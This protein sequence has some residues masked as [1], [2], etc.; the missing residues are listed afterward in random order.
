MRVLQ[1]VGAPGPTVKFIDQVTRDTPDD[2][3]FVYFSWRAALAARYDVVHI[4]WPEFFVRSRWPAVGAVKRAVTLIL[5]RRWRARGVPI[6]HT[7][8]NLAPHSELSPRQA[9]VVERI[10]GGAAVRVALNAGTPPRPGI[11]QVVIPHGDYRERFGQLPPAHRVPGRLLAI[12]RIEPYKNVPRLIRLA[13]QE[14]WELRVVGEPGPGMR[15]P[16]QEQLDALDAG[17]RISSVLAHVDDAALVTEVT[18][19]QLVVLPYRDLHN[20]GILLVALSL[21]RP[22]LVPRNTSTEEIA[23]A[24]GDGWVCLF[25]GEL[26]AA[27]ITSALAATA[28]LDGEPA[29]EDRSWARIAAAYADVYRRARPCHR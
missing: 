1:S 4:H 15:R 11:P 21:N 2:I 28:S 3:H 9:S 16:L 10:I 25:D 14:G 17:H 22:V 6:V 13:E 26:D 7:V 27:D 24:V 5:L 20:S 12:G 23:A 19:A 8:H 29:L 18:A